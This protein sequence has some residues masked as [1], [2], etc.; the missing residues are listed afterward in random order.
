[1]SL[2]QALPEVDDDLVESALLGGVGLQEWAPQAG[3]FVC[4]GSSVAAATG[5][6]LD[7]AFGE[8]LVELLPFL[9][10]GVAV[11]LAR[12]ELAAS[13]EEGAVVPE[14]VLGID[15]HAMLGGGQVFMP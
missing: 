1:M 13:G 4:A 5:T 3:V 12:P 7:L 15:R 14:H 9:R 11:L 8:V 6:E 2:G 10:C